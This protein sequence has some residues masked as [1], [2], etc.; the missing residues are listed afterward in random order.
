MIVL[1]PITIVPFITFIDA[2]VLLPATLNP[3]ASTDTLE[4][5]ETD[6]V[7][8]ATA[9]ILAEVENTPDGA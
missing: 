9:P 6:A 5:T 3:A 1:L 2:A 8:I 4:P 7:E